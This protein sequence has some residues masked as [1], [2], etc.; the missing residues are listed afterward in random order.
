M[1]NKRINF[2]QRRESKEKYKKYKRDY[3]IVEEF[4]EIKRVN[5][6]NKDL[7]L[8]DL[9]KIGEVEIFLQFLFG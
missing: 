1:G 8:F 3:K 6:K 9:W 5:G 2:I 7:G 4:K